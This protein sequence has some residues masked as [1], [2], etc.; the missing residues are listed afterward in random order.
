MPAHGESENLST[1]GVM[2]PTDAFLFLQ[3]LDRTV[4]RCQ[5]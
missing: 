3:K 1:F 5:S 4:D 2:Y